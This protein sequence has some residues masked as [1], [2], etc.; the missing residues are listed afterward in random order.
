MK[1]FLNVPSVLVTCFLLH[2]LKSLRLDENPIN[3]VPEVAVAAK[4]LVGPSLQKFNDEGI[5]FQSYFSP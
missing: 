5:K 2:F 4:V 1:V 3:E